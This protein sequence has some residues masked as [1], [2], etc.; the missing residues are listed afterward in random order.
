MSD[1]ISIN[2]I[3]RLWKLLSLM[4]N[5]TPRAQLANKMG[6]S[7]NALSMDLYRLKKFGLNIKHSRLTDCYTILY[8]DYNSI[9]F[10]LTKEEFFYVYAIIN[11]IADE[12]DVESVRQKL[13]L[14]INAD[15]NP[16]FDSGPSYGFTKVNARVAD[17][18]YHLKDDVTYRRKVVFMYSDDLRI[19]HPYKLVH[20][21]F[22]WYM[23]AFCEDR[24]AFRKFKLARM[25]N[26]KRTKDNYEQQDF[27]LNDILGDAWYLQHNPKKINAPYPIKILFK[28]QSGETIQEYNFHKTQKFE[29]CA[30]GTIVEW[31]LSYLEEFASWLMQWIP[32]IEIQEPQELKDIINTKINKYKGI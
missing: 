9:P 18:L 22:S 2:V 16:V 19:V 27:D 11:N 26:Y 15:T 12:G 14:A 32:N 10:R 3:C 23:I 24:N 30:E 1:G 31:E 17:L 25:S 28:G 21:P 6:Y 13:E 29:I 7:N 20:T 5:K 4:L 8:P